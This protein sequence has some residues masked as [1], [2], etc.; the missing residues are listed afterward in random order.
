[1]E[2]NLAHSKVWVGKAPETQWHVEGLL[3]TGLSVSFSSKQCRAWFYKTE[4][5]PKKTIES[6][7]AIK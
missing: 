5:S 7:I 2:E 6:V 3:P 1:M 4:G